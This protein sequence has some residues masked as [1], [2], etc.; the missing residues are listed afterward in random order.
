VRRATGAAEATP[1]ILAHGTVLATGGIAA[2]LV[3]AAW[4]EQL[5]ILDECLE[6]VRVTL[7]ATL[8]MAIEM[9]IDARGKITRV[10]AKVPPP[11]DERFARCVESVTKK[12]LRFS[13]PAPGRPTLARTELIIGI[14]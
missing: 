6:G 13:V 5:G 2:P 3:D 8:R 12:S 11:F 4:R 10:V 9:D 7:R 1:R 14:Q